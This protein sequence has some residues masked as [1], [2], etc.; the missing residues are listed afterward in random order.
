MISRYAPNSGE[1]GFTLIEL[2]VTTTL[3][4]LVL[5]LL[6]GGLRFGVRAWDG[7]QAHGV[8]MDELRVV[9]DLLRR[10]IEQAYPYYDVADPIRPR[11]DFQGAEDR[12]TFLAPAPQAT[13]PSGRARITIFGERRGSD[14]LLAMQAEPELGASRNGAW[15]APLLRH[16]AAVRFS[17]FGADGWS[18]NWTKAGA[19][20]SLVRVHVEF[21]P[22]DG[23]L[24]PDLIVAPQIG[25]DA[26]CIYDYPTKRCQG[27]P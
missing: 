16:V 1:A 15:S 12:L 27:R 8:R 6:F 4:S 9:Q 3:L 22:G 21:R 24:W 5:L 7:A 17:Y 26:G 14:M 18:T 11:V 19:M 13:D 23:R 2:L 10:E 20:P 25:A